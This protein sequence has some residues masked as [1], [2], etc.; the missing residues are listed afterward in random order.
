MLVQMKNNKDATIYPFH[1]ASEFVVYSEKNAMQKIEEQLAKGKIAENDPTMKFTIKIQKTL[2]RLRKEKS[3]Q[4]ENISKYIP[5]ILHDCHFMVKTGEELLHENYCVNHGNTSI[6]NIQ[7][8]GRNNSTTLNK[9]N[10]KMQNSTSF[11]HEAKD[12]KIQPTEIQV[13]YNVVNLYSSD[14]FKSLLN[15]SKMTMP[16]WKKKAKLNL[17]D[18]QQLL[19][20]CLTECYFIYNNVIW[21]LENS[22]PISLSI[23]VV[24]AECYLQRIKH[25]S[26][27]QA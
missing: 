24:L 2:C 25:I 5:Q 22:G 13:S 1:K 16:N 23:T 19:K 17:T 21:T 14:L 6:W 8:P 15:F 10:H 3:L 27:T 9:N 18:I 20:L 26:T 11:V 4:I 7:L 12:W